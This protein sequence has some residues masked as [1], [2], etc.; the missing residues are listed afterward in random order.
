MEA[1]FKITICACMCGRN[2]FSLLSLITED[3]VPTIDVEI[4]CY[5]TEQKGP[6]SNYRR[7]N[8]PAG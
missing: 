4:K 1:D 5:Y 8:L 6:S 2:F 7:D 3:A